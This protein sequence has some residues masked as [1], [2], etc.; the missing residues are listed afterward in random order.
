M[1]SIKSLIAA[2][3]QLPTLIFDEIDTGISGE[4]AL[5]VGQLL[6]SLATHHQV[7][8]ITHLPQIAAK[9]SAH[10]FVHKQEENGHTRTKVQALHGE[11]R[12]L[13]IARMIGGDQPSDTA[14]AGARELL[15]NV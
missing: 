8:V 3:T 5:Q 9:G 10:F 1:L 12:V 15:G 6:E 14:I 4:V 11:Q 13:A 7:L 2:Q